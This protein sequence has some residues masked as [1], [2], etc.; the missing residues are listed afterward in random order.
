MALDRIARLVQRAARDSDVVRSRPIVAARAAGGSSGPN[1]AGAGTLTSVRPRQLSVIVDAP[2]MLLPPEGTGPP[3]DP[4]IFSLPPVKQPASPGPGK[5]RTPAGPA[6][7][8]AGPAPVPTPTAPFR[9]PSVAPGPTVA[10]PSPVPPRGA[11]VPPP[12]AGPIQTPA[13]TSWL[14][15]PSPAYIAEIPAA[16]PTPAPGPLAAA[17]P[18]PSASPSPMPPLPMTP[19]PVPTPW[20]VAPVPQ[21]EAEPP[22][23]LIFSGWPA[24]A[25]SPPSGRAWPTPVARGESCGCCVPVVALAATVAANAQTAITGITAIARGIG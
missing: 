23:G 4:L 16:P 19:S 11:P 21:P 9:P 25:P 14:T 15:Q 24:P 2:S 18:W 1:A 13:P 3:P 12:S 7:V 10:G 6:P 17:P 5:A 22:C 8:A 20:E